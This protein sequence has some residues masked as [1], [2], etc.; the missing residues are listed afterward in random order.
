MSETDSNDLEIQK[1]QEIQIL[2]QRL[3]ELF[4]RLVTDGPGV[5]CEE[6][7]SGMAGRVYKILGV[8]MDK[9]PVAVKLF[10]KEQFGGNK[11]EFAYFRD[12]KDE[13]AKYP[14]LL[15]VFGVEKFIHEGKQFGAVLM[16]YC[17]KGDM[18]TLLEEN[19]GEARMIMIENF[20]PILCAVSAI[21]AQSRVHRD[22]KPR[23]IFIRGDNSLVIGDFG[24]MTYL[25]NSDDLHGTP[26]FMAPEMI[27]S[28][29]S[30]SYKTDIWA[31]G[32][33]MI[34]IV[35]GGMNIIQGEEMS[36]DEYIPKEFVGI[37]KDEDHVRN[38]IKLIIESIMTAVP[39]ISY[40][41]AM[42]N[43]CSYYPAERSS[44]EQIIKHIEQ[45]KLEKTMEKEFEKPE[46]EVIGPDSKE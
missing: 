33:T 7:G 27:I 16:E 28:K 39:N 9:K 36:L 25:E 6:V 24:F 17:E 19:P 18:E 43:M 44:P 42:S 14:G 1:V 46:K 12:F 41:E 30:N 10:S 23:N 13:M 20:I 15:K 32:M 5:E 29:S 45:K 34:Y 3:L 40:V 21:H 35:S 31:L 2:N 38:K 37:M 22:L 26:I 11:G 8:E 4:P